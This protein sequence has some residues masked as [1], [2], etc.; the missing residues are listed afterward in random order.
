MIEINLDSMN[1]SNNK[2]II[3]G[4]NIFEKYKVTGFSL[5]YE[6]QEF[7]ILILKIFDDNIKI[8]GDIADIIRDKMADEFTEEELV[9]ALAK[10]KFNNINKKR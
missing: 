8:T 2:M 6:A 7:P 4:E 5:D 3:D 10:K 9:K 1:A